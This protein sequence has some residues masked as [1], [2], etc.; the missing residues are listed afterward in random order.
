M[1][2]KRPNKTRQDLFIRER[3]FIT[4][5]ASF[6][7]VF[8][9]LIFIASLLGF[10]SE[11]TYGYRNFLLA[12]L[13]K[14]SKWSGGYGPQWFVIL[15]DDI[16]SLSSGPIILLFL[17]LISIYLFVKEKKE[18]LKPYLI[19]IIGRGFFSLLLKTIFSKTPTFD[20]I[21]LL[22]LNTNPYPSGHAMLSVIFYL[23]SAYFFSK[24]EENHKVRA[25]FFTV[26]F[27]MPFLIGLS[28]IFIGAHSPDQVI[29]GWAAGFY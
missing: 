18:I 27:I 2:Y 26:G 15:M 3:Q 13:G 23:T 28:R 11:I 29:A 1:S 12:N 22:L 8:S 17:I 7:A 19:V 9:L 6:I 4:V 20:L 24:S 21:K 16:S 14:Y 25:L 5:L 10:F